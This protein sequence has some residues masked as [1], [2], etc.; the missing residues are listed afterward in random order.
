MA[1]LHRYGKPLDDGLEW[2]AE[3]DKVAGIIRQQADIM[4]LDLQQLA[5][6]FKAT[7]AALLETLQAAMND[8]VSAAAAGSGGSVL[9][10]S[11]EHQQKQV[12]D[13]VQVDCTA[14]VAHVR[15]G[16]GK[17]LY[18]VLLSSLHR[19]GPQQEQNQA[20]AQ[21]GQKDNQQ[22]EK[23]PKQVEQPLT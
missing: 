23:Q 2:P 3:A 12:V 16:F 5:A 10:H 15:D 6:C 20:H 7:A 19:S 22:T 9:L 4:L 1:A 13:E 8:A 11:A 21:D 18:V 14:A 17:L